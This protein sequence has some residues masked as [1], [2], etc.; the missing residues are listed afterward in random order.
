[1]EGVRRPRYRGV[2]REEVLAYFDREAAHRRCREA[3]ECAR[4]R[5]ASSKSLVVI[6]RGQSIR[7]NVHTKC[8]KTAKY[9][10]VPQ[11]QKARER[12][13]PRPPASL[14]PILIATGYTAVSQKVLAWRAESVEGS[15]APP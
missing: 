14:R 13:K 10:E 9:A 6:R 2:T 5:E 12:L 3:L 15:R 11:H 4:E 7:S 8:I 1:M